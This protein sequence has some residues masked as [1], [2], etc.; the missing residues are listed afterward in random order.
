MQ[1]RS[2]LP[3]ALSELIDNALMATKTNQES[4][5]VVITLAL[6][7]GIKPQS[8]LIAVWDNG[9]GFQRRLCCHALSSPGPVMQLLHEYGQVFNIRRRAGMQSESVC[10][11]CAASDKAHIFKDVLQF[12]EAATG[13]I[14]QVVHPVFTQVCLQGVEWGRRS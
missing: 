8:G 3:Y 10:R 2:V 6:S 1:G 13:G 11:Y 7:G 12:V 14:F 5:Q 9:E 4:R